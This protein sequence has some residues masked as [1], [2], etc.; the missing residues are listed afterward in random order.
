MPKIKVKHLSVTEQ[1]QATSDYIA[2]K[3]RES[4]DR[5]IEAGNRIGDAADARLQRIVDGEEELM[6]GTAGA[7]VSALAL[8]LRR[9]GRLVERTEAKV[10]TEATPGA[11]LMPLREVQARVVEA[12]RELDGGKK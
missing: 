8:A 6:P 5:I 11:V 12:P 3:H 2:Q 1:R 10:Q 9:A 4:I 7:I